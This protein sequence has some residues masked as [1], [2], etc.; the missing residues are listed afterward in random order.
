MVEQVRAPRF[1]YSGDLAQTPLP[2]V[3]ATIYQYKAP[4]ILECRRESEVRQ[5]YIDEGNIIFATSSERA[6]SLGDRL[7]S[8]GLITQEQ[9]D[10]SARAL[11]DGKRQGTIL[12]EMGAIQP[13]DLFVEVREQVQAIVWSVFEWES[14]SVTFEPGRDRHLEFIKLTIPIPLAVMQGARSIRDARLV[15]ARVGSKTTVLERAIGE[16][17]EDSLKLGP[18]E[19]A[20]LRKVDGRTTLFDLTN[21]PPLTPAVNGRIMYGL[22]ALKAIR[23]KDRIRIQVPVSGASER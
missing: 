20:I 17:A 21:L 11:G 19:L 12:V 3:L 9:Y 14:G 5:I 22:F 13:K 16:D 8:R 4:G 10:Q 23:V 1:V 7:M 6:D 15:I 2:E 18:E